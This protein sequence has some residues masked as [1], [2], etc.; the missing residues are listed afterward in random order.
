LVF[1]N[2]GEQLPIVP[3]VLIFP[4]LLAWVDLGVILNVPAAPLSNSYAESV[5]SIVG[6]EILLKKS[7]QSIL[8]PA[9][10]PMKA[11][12]PGPVGTSDGPVKVLFKIAQKAV[13][14]A[15]VVIKT[16]TSLIDPLN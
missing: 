4:I 10:L 1:A 9:V 2:H 8:L 11:A 6:V 3:S 5:W 13:L 14:V 7:K 15:G 12:Y 16:G